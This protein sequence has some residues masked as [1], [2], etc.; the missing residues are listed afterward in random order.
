MWLKLGPLGLDFGFRAGILTSRLGGGEKEE[1]ERTRE[2]RVRTKWL[3]GADGR[4][5]GGGGDGDDNS[6]DSDDGEYALSG[7]SS[8]FVELSVALLNVNTPTQPKPLPS[9]R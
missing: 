7:Q 5:R 1:G 2:E 6:D 8:N 3:E 9:H 4:R